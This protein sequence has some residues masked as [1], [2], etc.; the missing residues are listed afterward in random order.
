M[1][2]GEGGDRDEHGDLA[3]LFDR[4]EDVTVDAAEGSARR[5]AT[6]AAPLQPT[7]GT[8]TAAHQP[9]G[10]HGDDEASASAVPWQRPGATCWAAS[11]PSP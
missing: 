1:A 8:T 4:P 5:R 10:E 3:D 7:S 11:A 2:G 6:V 9:I